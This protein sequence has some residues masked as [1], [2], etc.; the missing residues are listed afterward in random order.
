MKIKSK[1]RKNDSSFAG[2]SSPLPGSYAA[3]SKAISGPIQYK[4]RNWDDLAFVFFF[5]AVL[6]TFIFETSIVIPKIYSKDSH[7]SAGPVIHYVAGLFILHN[8]LGNF[9][10]I[11]RHQSTIKGKLLLFGNL[12]SSSFSSKISSA[13]NQRYC[14]TC[15][16]Y[17]PPRSYHCSS[18]GVCILKR[19]HHC[20]FARACIGY[21]NYRYFIAL[22]FYISIGSLYVSILNMFFIWDL[23]GGFTFYNFMS[24]TFPFIF[25][26]F[27]LLHWYSTMCCLISI[28]NIAAFLFTTG[29]VFYHGSMV[30]ANQTVHERAKSITDFDLGNWRSNVEQS[31]GSRWILTFISPI[32]YSKLPGNGK[33]F[34]SKRDYN[35]NSPKT[36]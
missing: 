35:L 20:T 34:P 6:G 15:E 33:D 1:S 28:I 4:N 8:I 19:D 27:G 3:T 25:W 30:I 14:F 23:L 13:N 10:Q 16:T 32:I 18:C 17:L 12:P 7:S 22:I 31:F 24:H 9:I 11:I 2:L 36:K 29:L 5:V 26:L 21:D